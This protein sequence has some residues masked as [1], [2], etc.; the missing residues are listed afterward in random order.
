M[1]RLS[2]L[3]SLRR[4]WLGIDRC[5]ART[6]RSAYHAPG[7]SVRFPCYRS[8]GRPWPGD[9]LRWTAVQPVARTVDPPDGVLRFETRHDRL[10]SPYGF[11]QDVA[12]NGTI[13]MMPESFQECKSM[14]S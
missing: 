3:A 8:R 9:A 13:T 6:A 4:N 5:I 1:S 12:R 7:N 14:S 2:Q 10:A 11:W